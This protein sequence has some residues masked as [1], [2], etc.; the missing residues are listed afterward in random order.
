ME[1]V[2]ISSLI[3]INGG[4]IMEDGLFRTNRPAHEIRE[5]L[6]D[7]LMSYQDTWINNRDA[8]FIRK[9]II[10]NGSQL[11]RGYISK[12]IGAIKYA[13]PRQQYDDNVQAVVEFINNHFHVMI[14]SYSHVDMLFSRVADG[15]IVSASIQ[16]TYHENIADEF[17]KAIMKSHGL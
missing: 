12:F 2:T 7:E 9:R 8:E 16:R 17:I 13:Y 5:I 14:E 11:Y 1:Y 3:T 4:A 6:N 15:R 10:Q